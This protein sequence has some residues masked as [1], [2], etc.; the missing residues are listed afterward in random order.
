M[1]LFEDR[2][3][4]GRRVAQELST[5]A[6]RDDVIVLG[7]PR[8]GVPVAFEV[9]RAL[10]APLDVFLVRKLGVP[11]HRELA[12]GAIASG[13]VRVL[14][15]DVV[16]S[17]GI[18]PEA[19]EMVAGSEEE[20]LERRERTYRGN[21]PPPD[22]SG[23]TAI[24]VDDGLATGASMRAAVAALRERRPARIVVAVPVAPAETCATLE[25]EIDDVVCVATPRPFMSVGAW[26]RDFSQTT[27]DEVRALLRRAE[28][29]LP[30][31]R[32]SQT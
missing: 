1:A 25:T 26:Y 29:M 3:D 24:L 2:A 20:E 11:G 15:L 5:Y 32:T 13:G 8:G 10:R 30:G 6:G 28:E 21:R 18:P 22:V 23:C 7:L 4:A 17:L 27:D 9:A 19:I 31:A 12:M 16:R 14:N